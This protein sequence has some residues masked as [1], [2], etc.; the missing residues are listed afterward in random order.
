MWRA[1][2]A[3]ISMISS[4]DSLA[5]APTS[6]RRGLAALVV[7]SLAGIVGERSPEANGVEHFLGQGEASGYVPNTSF[8]SIGMGVSSCA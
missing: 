8:N 7:N 2:A 3:A 1:D 5:T 6:R 4:V